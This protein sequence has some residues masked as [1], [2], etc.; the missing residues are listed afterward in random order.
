MPS[1]R[2]VALVLLVLVHPTLHAAPIKVACIGDS[3]TQGSGLSNPALESYP[4]KLQGLLG[5]EYQVRN[6]GVSG[7]TLLKKGDYPYWN[8]AAFKQSRDW[9]P[10][11]VIIKLGTN[12]A[13]PQNWRHGTNFVADYEALIDAYASLPS[14]P[15]ILLCTPCPVFGTGAFDIRPGTVATNIAPAI[16]ELAQ[17]LGLEVLDLHAL[18]AGHREWFPDTVHPNARGTTVLAALA[19]TAIQRGHPA[20]PPPTLQVETLPAKRVR[21][22]WPAPWAG[23]VLQ[24]A[25]AL[26]ETNT[27]WTVVE[28]YAAQSGASMFV[29][30]TATGTLRLYRLWQP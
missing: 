25:T 19:H 18:L 20:D 24:S 26:R 29:T 2:F 12:D 30:N 6:Y 7:R 28:Q 14:E 11:L 15:R 23:L 17:R 16:Q 27:A 22:Q 21:L 3:I 4:A 8:E 9:N 13:K 5:A 10:D 1:L